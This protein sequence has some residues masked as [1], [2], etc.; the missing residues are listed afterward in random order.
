MSLYITAEGIVI[1][2]K[3]V[4]EVGKVTYNQT[5]QKYYFTVVLYGLDNHYNI[6]FDTEEKA[7]GERNRLISLMKDWNDSISIRNWYTII[8]NYAVYYICWR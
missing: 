7:T 6:D 4:I 1:R 8:N 5:T 3:H 2:A